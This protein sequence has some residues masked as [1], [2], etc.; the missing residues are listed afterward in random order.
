MPD[1]FWPGDHRAGA[2][3]TDAALLAAMVEVEAA[4]LDA[5]VH[6]ELAPPEAADTLADL[7]GPADLE[8]IAEGAESSGNPVTELVKLLRARVGERNPV[9]KTW[10]HRGLT[11]QDVLDT[12]LILCLR[13]VFD[14]L[15]REIDAQVA[16][17]AALARAHVDTPMVGRTLTQQAV[18]ITFGG[19]AAAWLDGLLDAAEQVR[20][21]AAGLPVQFGGAAGTL[22]ASTEIARL[23]GVSDPAAASVDLVEAAAAT[24]RLS[25]RR[26]WHT[27]RGPFTRVGDALVGWCDAAGHIATD[28]ATLSRPEIGEVREPA[29]AGRG[30]SSTMP[31]KRN[32][33]LS[34]LIRRTALSAPMLGATLHTAAATAVDERPDGAWHTEWATLAA[35]GRR[36]VVAASHLTELL[37]GLEVDTARMAATLAAAGEDVYAEQRSMVKVAEV[38]ADRDAY[39]GISALEVGGATERAQEF[40]DARK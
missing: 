35:L 39:L 13:E 4:W 9:A 33:V 17:L 40:L 30:G 8:A 7:V 19:K 10:L 18:P 26:P 20:V 29:V 6:A 16:A 25:A 21:V 27:I 32:P 3:M 31:Q 12:A 5:L 14:Q 2:A 22:A 1:L 11:S 28:V 38:E 23:R 24:L 15:R 37:S 34:V 36:T